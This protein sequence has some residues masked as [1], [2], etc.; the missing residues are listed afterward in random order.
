MTD[1]SFSLDTT[2]E[3]LTTTYE[4][5]PTW[6]MV[7]LPI[8]AFN[9]YG[10]FSSRHSTVGAVLKSIGMPLALFV[11]SG[12]LGLTGHWEWGY[13]L[14][15]ALGYNGFKH[16]EF[17]RTMERGMYG[18]DGYD[19]M[20][21]T[22]IATLMFTI[23]T[24]MP[25]DILSSEEERA[26]AKA[27]QQQQ[28]AEAMAAYQQNATATLAAHSDLLAETVYDGAEKRSR[29]VL[30][31][32]SWR[33][34]MRF[35]YI[36]S[37]GAIGELKVNAES[38]Q[39]IEAFRPIMEGFEAVQRGERECVIVELSEVFSHGDLDNRHFTI[40]GFRFVNEG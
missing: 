31:H 19:E 6:V 21:Y 35:D 39:W 9:Y 36:D 5:M 20:G 14:L 27:L 33:N 28:E 11:A 25:M 32:G 13:P 18:M 16:F 37:N 26:T 29:Q 15:A 7:V 1:N 30:V 10:V 12:A 8:F 17:F 22:I 3:F 23:L 40:T 34:P 38:L 2:L 4:S 24:F